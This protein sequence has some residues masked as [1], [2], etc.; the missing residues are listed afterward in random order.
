[1]RASAQCRFTAVGRVAPSVATAAVRAVVALPLHRQ[2][3][4]HTVAPS[5]RSAIAPRTCMLRMA[6]AA[7]SS[8]ASVRRAVSDGAAPSDR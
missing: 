4:R 8:E 2:R 6:C 1:M 3:Q 7:S 5:R